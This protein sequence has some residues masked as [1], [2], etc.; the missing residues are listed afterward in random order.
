MAAAQPSKPKNDPETATQTTPRSTFSQRGLHVRAHSCVRWCSRLYHHHPSPSPFSSSSTSSRT[1]THPLQ[2]PSASHDRGHHFWRR[3]WCVF[4]APSPTKDSRKS[5]D[6]GEGQDVAGRWKK[7]RK[8]VKELEVLMN[9]EV[10]KNGS[11]IRICGGAEGRQ[12]GEAY[13]R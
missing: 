1:R 10:D 2:L 4:F 6:E 5:L 13:A 9:V 11:L 3:T 12:A 7:R 8:H